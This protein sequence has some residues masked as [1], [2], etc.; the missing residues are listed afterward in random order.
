M[1]PQ[2][3]AAALDALTPQQL[4]RMSHADLYNARNYVPREQQNKISPYEHRAFAR[5]ATAENPWMGVPIALATPLYQA[6]KAVDG[7]SRSRPSLDQVTQGF[8]GVGEGLWQAFQ[9]FMRANEKSQQ[10][11]HLK[12]LESYARN[13]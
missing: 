5:E 13:Q 7:R 10:T 9:E 1:S 12:A 8:T 3:I 4:G 2:E 11:S 6:Y